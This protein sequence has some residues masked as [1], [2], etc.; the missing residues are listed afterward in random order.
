VSAVICPI[1]DK[2]TPADAEDPPFCCERCKLVDLGRWLDGH[3]A[4]P[5]T[6]VGD[7]GGGFD[8]DP[9]AFGLDSDRDDGRSSGGDDDADR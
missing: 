3:Y 6:P 7:A 4:V 8:L 9:S 2:P 1:C 5:G